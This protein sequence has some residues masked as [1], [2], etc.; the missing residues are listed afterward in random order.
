MSF[1][2][3]SKPPCNNSG[4]VSGRFQLQCMKEINELQF[5]LVKLAFLE[6]C[7]SLFSGTCTQKVLLVPPCVTP[8][9]VLH[10]WSLF[11]S[12]M[13][14]PRTCSI[15][16][17]FYSLMGSCIIGRSDILVPLSLHISCKVWHVNYSRYLTRP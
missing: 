6:L 3:T 16:M 8:V 4:G 10:V 5:S 2:I 7:M 11:E 12:V 17:Q 1:Y 14:L 13:E 15:G 9:A